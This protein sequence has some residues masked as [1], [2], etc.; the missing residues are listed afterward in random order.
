MRVALSRHHTT[1][2]GTR[3]VFGGSMFPQ[4][5]CAYALSAP[6]AVRRRRCGLEVTFR[7]AGEHLYVRG[8]NRHGV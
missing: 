2:P 4:K 5:R 3:P 8:G 1:A 6:R 7:F